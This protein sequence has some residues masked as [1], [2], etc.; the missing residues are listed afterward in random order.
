VRRFGGRRLR[1]RNPACSLPVPG[2]VDGP[3]F[4]KSY[5]LN[6]V[7]VVLA[8]FPGLINTS[9]I[10]LL[11]SVMGHDLGVTSGTIG[12]L[13]LLSDAALGFGCLLAAEL[14]RRVAGRTLFYALMSA[15]LV[16]SLASALAPNFTVLFVAAVAHGLFA[17]MLFVVMSPPLLSTFGSA[18]I[19]MTATVL[20]PSLFGAATLGPVLGGAL[21]APEHWRWMFAAE[22]VMSLA[23][24]A[25][26]RL[27]LGK[28]E[29]APTTDPPD[30]VALTIAALGSIGVFIGVGSLAERDLTYAPAALPLV[31]GLLAFVALFAFEA[32]APH[33]LVPVRRLFSSI[34]NVG[35]V[36]SII[37]SACFAATQE[38]VALSLARLSG[39]GLAA[40]GF[41]FWPEFLAALAAGIVFGRLVGSRWVV[42]IGTMGLILSAFAALVTRAVM[43][44]DA[45]SAPWIVVLSGLGAGFAVTP[46]LFVVVLAFERAVVGRAIALLNVLRLGGGFI[47]VPGVE[48]TIG[49]RAWT[50]FH[51]LAPGLGSRQAVRHFIVSGD[52]GALPLAPLRAALGEAL[53]YALAIVIVLAIAGAAINVVLLAVAHVPLRQPDLARL[54]DGQPA[55]T[56]RA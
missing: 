7:N 23:A 39:L 21:V 24:L 14:A 46:G 32:V 17:G 1:P 45:S 4:E 56:A 38:C 34:A 6:V 35:A 49:D 51:A 36:G 43:P 15:S 52:P 50:R 19:R 18:K 8:L 40:T 3:R 33:P 22:V 28:R 5:P 9:A 20:V 13:P 37:G 41:A 30:A 48:H 44:V 42:L 47:S 16:T 11:A 55:L 53:D 10:A 54:D 29:P 26:G 2:Y 12:R 27:T 25:L 31:A